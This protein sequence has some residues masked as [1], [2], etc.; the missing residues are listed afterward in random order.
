MHVPKDK[1]D[2]RPSFDLSILK[3]ENS[4]KLF[5]DVFKYFIEEVKKYEDKPVN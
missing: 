4:M 1:L 2:K 5:I 3:D